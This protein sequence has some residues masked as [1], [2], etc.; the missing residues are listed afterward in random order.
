MTQQNKA[1][2]FNFVDLLQFIYRWKKHL[3]IICGIAAVASAI[4]SSPLFI[5]PKYKAEAIFYPTTINSISNAMFTDLNKRE[6]D[7]LAFGEEEEAEN[8]LQILQSSELK[9]RIVRNF[10]LMKHYRI[11]PKGS[12]PMTKL[13]KKLDANIDFKRT[14]YLSVKVTVLDEDKDMAARIANGITELYDTIKTEIQKQVANE[15]FKIIEGQYKAKEAEVWEFR[16]KLK[17]LA[18]QGITNYEEQSRAVSEEIFKLKSKGGSPSGLTE[19]EAQ[20]TKLAKFGSDFTYYNETLILELENLSLARKR[21]EK[22]KVD[23]EQT[24]THKFI[25]NS[26]TPAEKKSYPIRWLI[27]L[28]TVTATFVLMMIVMLFTENWKK[29][30]GKED[31]VAE[32]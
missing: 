24:M 29:I 16:V 9:S 4:F 17:E 3:I 26:A 11:D 6:M 8:A 20:Q 27:V 5:K 19:L 25:V 12:Q 28:G 14:R 18:D 2:E 32:A 15:A 23:I 1:F 22:A 10:N 30:S 31:A 13:A 7:L 21:Y